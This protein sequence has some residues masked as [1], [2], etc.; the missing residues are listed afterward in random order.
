MMEIVP[1]VPP[2]TIRLPD[3]AELVSDR[4]AI[5]LDTNARI[6]RAMENPVRFMA[7]PVS[8]SHVA[9]IVVSALCFRVKLNWPMT[10]VVVAM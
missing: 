2:S 9:V 10:E 5:G 7:F 6:V 1:E 3:T 8:S 4:T